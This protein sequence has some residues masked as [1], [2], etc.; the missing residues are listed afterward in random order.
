M[1]TCK[2]DKE[3]RQELESLFNDYDRARDILRD[4]LDQV[5]VE[6]TDE[7]DEKSDKW[8]ESEAGG[9]AQSR[10][11]TI[12]RLRDEFEEAPDFEIEDL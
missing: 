5:A 6:W 12:E 7:M 2:L 9:N 4:A 3:K 10:L 1:A 8:K 11:D